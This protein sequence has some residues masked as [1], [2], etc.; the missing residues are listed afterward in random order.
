LLPQLPDEFDAGYRVLL[1]KDELTQGLKPPMYKA[2]IPKPPAE[3][4]YHKKIEEF[5]LDAGY[6]VKFLWRDD[7]IA[8]KHLLDHFIKQDYVIPMLEW[9]LEIDHNWSVKPGPYGRRLKKWLRPDLWAELEATYSGAGLE[10]T[11][12]AL[13]RTIT[14][15]RKVAVETGNL[16]GYAY[17]HDL[18]RRA[19]AYLE[20]ITTMPR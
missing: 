4:D 12:D 19:L 20:K 13:F 14:L 9:R 18:D 17:P 1:D 8:A 7:M 6:V 5:F 3:T 15:F 10:E 2:Y 11:R 16:L